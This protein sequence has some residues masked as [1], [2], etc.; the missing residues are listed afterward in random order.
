MFSWKEKNEEIKASN[1]V[2]LD[3]GVPGKGRTFQCRFL[4]AGLVKYSFGVCF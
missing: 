4:E 2:F 1:A 3:E